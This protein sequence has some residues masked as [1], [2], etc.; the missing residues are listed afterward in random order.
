MK[1]KVHIFNTQCILVTK[2]VTLSNLIA[3]ASLVS[4]I[5]LV[6]ARQTDRLLGLI[7]ANLF[8]VNNKDHKIEL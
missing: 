7:Y 3:T 6:T 2:S 5:R 8:K 1:V 4:E